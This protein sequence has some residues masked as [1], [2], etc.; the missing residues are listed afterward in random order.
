[1]IRTGSSSTS[2]SEAEEGPSTPARPLWK[3]MFTISR[4][5][6]VDFDATIWVGDLN[7]RID[8]SREA[9]EAA[10]KA[11]NLQVSGPCPVKSL[12]FPSPTHWGCTCLNDTVS[13]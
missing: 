3:R 2:G 5:V 10:V 6:T 7:Y 13:W 8:G 12:L 11:G 4:D 9:V 1:M